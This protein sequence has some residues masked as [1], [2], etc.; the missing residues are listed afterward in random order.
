MSDTIK[1]IG[2]AVS[3]VGF[4]IAMCAAMFYCI[5][6]QTERHEKEVM[7]LTETINN[8]TQVLTELSTLIHTIVIK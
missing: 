3:R 5:L 2:E 1:A 8:N 7:Q 4:P 6:V